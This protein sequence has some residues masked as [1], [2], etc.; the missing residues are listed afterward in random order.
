MSIYSLGIFLGSG[1]GYF[2]GGWVIG[3]VSVQDA[4]HVP[5]LGEIRPWQTAFLAV[6]LP[7]LAIAALLFT[8][9]EPLRTE[10]RDSP[11]RPMRMRSSIPTARMWTSA[12]TRWKAAC[13]AACWR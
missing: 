3:L 4:W 7:G 2:V 1:V 5:L 11:V 12:K 8:I 13:P 9:R 6:G 10:A